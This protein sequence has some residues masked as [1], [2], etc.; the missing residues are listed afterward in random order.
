MPYGFEFKSLKSSKR[1]ELD[2]YLEK[3]IFLARWRS[4]YMIVPPVHIAKFRTMWRF[5]RIF[6]TT[7]VKT[8][9]ILHLYWARRLMRMCKL[10]VWRLKVK[11]GTSHQ[12]W[13]LDL[14]LIKVLSFSLFLHFFFVVAN[15]T[16]LSVL[17]LNRVIWLIQNYVLPKTCNEVCGCMVFR[18]KFFRF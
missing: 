18:F 2:F 17:R 1:P 4:L 10:T 7:H 6:L 15:F 5:C 13:Q 8:T 9:L 12:L 11:D 14:W 3:Q 16:P